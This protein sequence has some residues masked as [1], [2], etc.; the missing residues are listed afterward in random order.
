M[1]PKQPFHHNALFSIA[2]IFM[3]AASKSVIGAAGNK[4]LSHLHQ[5]RHLC[6]IRKSNGDMELP[7]LGRQYGMMDHRRKPRVRKLHTQEVII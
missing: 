7:E 1:S 2:F 5:K 6:G 4:S 3:K